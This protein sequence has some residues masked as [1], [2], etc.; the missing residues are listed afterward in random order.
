MNDSRPF[1]LNLGLPSSVNLIRIGSRSQPNSG[2]PDHPMKVCCSPDHLELRDSLLGIPKSGRFLGPP[3]GCSKT[4]ITFALS[5]CYSRINQGG[6]KSRELSPYAGS[7]DSR[8][9]CGM[10]RLVQ[11]YPWI[12]QTVPRKLGSIWPDSH[13][14]VR[15]HVDGD[16]CT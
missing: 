13:A 9:T 8:P 12:I 4:S 10:K 1:E 14:P 7:P 6:E 3:A 5:L 2:T 16:C 11:D 15:L